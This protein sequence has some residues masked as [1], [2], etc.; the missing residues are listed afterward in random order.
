MAIPDYQT[1]ML[2]VLR[3]SG[4]GAR[5]RLSDAIEKLASDFGLTAEE[6]RELLPSGRQ[7]TFANRV[8]WART[9]LS[10]ALLLDNAQRGLFSITERGRQVLGENPS[11]I[12]RRYLRRFA[13]F[14]EFIGAV[15]EPVTPDGGGQTD[16][17]TPEEQL[18]ATY[19]E[20]RRTLAQELLERVKR[21]SPAYFERLVVDVL[22]AMGYAVRARTLGA[23]S[24]DPETAASMGSSTRICSVSMSSISKRSGGRI[25]CIGQQCR[26]LSGVSKGN[27]PARGC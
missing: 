15:R 11:R 27:V 26:S 9:Y 5:H 3:L 21:S 14:E 12:D 16:E 17:R 19:L 7:S 13:E 4:D 8:G 1:L 20:L 23:R 25:Q 2:P 6:R 18:D 10:K 24:D 22:V